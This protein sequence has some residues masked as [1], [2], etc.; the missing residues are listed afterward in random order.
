M[1]IVEDPQLVDY[2]R[3]KQIALEMCPISNMR[4]KVFN[5]DQAIHPIKKLFDL[6]CLVTVNTDDPKMFHNSL[7]MEYEYLQSIGFSYND[8]LQLNL[9]AAKAA[10]C[11]DVVKEKLR[12][13]INFK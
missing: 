13:Q 4:T 9:N 6:G 8:L 10:W 7:V 11:D 12:N 3:E 5:A 1:T 2:V